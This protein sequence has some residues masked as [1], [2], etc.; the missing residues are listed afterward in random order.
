M[1]RVYPIP[2]GYWAGFVISFKN[3]RGYGLGMRLGD[4]RSD[5]PKRHTCLPELYNRSY[6]RFF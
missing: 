1:E 4:S 6:T 3:F 5:Y 2:E